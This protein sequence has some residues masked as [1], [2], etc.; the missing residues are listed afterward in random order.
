MDLQNMSGLFYPSQTLGGP[1]T[2]IEYIIRSQNIISR[3]M[4]SYFGILVPLGLLAGIISLTILIKNKLKHQMLE[5]LDFYLL[6]LA[7]TEISIILYSFTSTTRPGYL[8]TSNLS[9]GVLSVFF[10]ISYFF[11]QYLLLMM[12]FMLIIMDNS[13]MA[14]IVQN[15]LGCVTLTLIFSVLMSV[16]TVSLLGT[17]N[18]LQN[19]TYCQLD[20]LNAK[21]E[22]DFTKFTVGFCVPSIILLIFYILLIVQARSADNATGNE[23]VQAH[24]V[25]LFNVSV[26][27]ICRLFY[28][29]ML[30]RRTSLKIHGLYLSPNEEL[31][32]NIAELVVFSG[33]CIRLIFI[34]ALHT[35]C[36]E[37]FKNSLQFL[38]KCGRTDTSNNV[39]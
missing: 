18:R 30:I 22:Y 12:F 35:P 2:D 29:I 15:R 24:I 20:P 16:A 10:N 36:R 37:G 13:I 27:F 34:L 1:Y 8:E 39:I 26:M 17:Y 32:M 31:V 19:I 25:I 33:S 3:V 11:S 5:N 28:N 23:K 21:P 38:R 6:I 7:S 14:N 9:C 4:H